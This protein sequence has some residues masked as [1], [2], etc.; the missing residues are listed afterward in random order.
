MFSDDSDQ[1]ASALARWLQKPFVSW[2]CLAVMSIALLAVI[3]AIVTH[4]WW[5]LFISLLA[6]VE[7]AAMYFGSILAEVLREKEIEIERLRRELG[8]H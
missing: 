4:V 2:Y 1:I 8:T 6:F 3:G 7:C 5:L